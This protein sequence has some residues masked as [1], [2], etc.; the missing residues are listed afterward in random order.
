[1]WRVESGKL[2]DI[3]SDKWLPHS[4]FLVSSGNNIYEHENSKV[5]MLI[6]KKKGWEQG[7]Y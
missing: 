7:T 3:W 4:N 5:K 6:N 2:I 1:M